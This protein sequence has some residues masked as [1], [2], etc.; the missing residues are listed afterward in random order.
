MKHAKQ[1]K[2]WHCVSLNLCKTFDSVSHHALLDAAPIRG[3]PGMYIDILRTLYHNCSSTFSWE[4][5]SDYMRV[6]LR[7]GIKQGD[8]ISPFMFNL[9][10]AE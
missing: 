4:D 10:A 8:P 1:R 2:K 9:M 6:T 5:Q 3:L 7:R